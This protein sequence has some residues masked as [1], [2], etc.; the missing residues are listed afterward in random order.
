MQIVLY[1]PTDTKNTSNARAHAAKVGWQRSAKAAKLKERQRNLNGILPE[2]L[3][4]TTSHGRDSA[5]RHRTGYLSED[6]DNSFTPVL[7][8]NV[9]SSTYGAAS[10]PTIDNSK[11]LAGAEVAEFL[12]TFIWPNVGGLVVASHWFQDFCTVPT[13]YHAQTAA[14][15]TYRGLMGGEEYLERKLCHFS[16]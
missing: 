11:G 3:E 15:A 9:P 4:K 10:L 14:S 8:R 12:G 5:L 1:K 2:R 16:A 7:A 13:L 6:F